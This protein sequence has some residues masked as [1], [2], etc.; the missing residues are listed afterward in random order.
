M[1]GPQLNAPH[2]TESSEGGGKDASVDGAEL[3]ELAR[4]EALELGP[5]PPGAE[6]EIWRENAEAGAAAR[7][8]R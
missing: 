6:A 7:R 3:R 8:P 5:E 4:Q 1:A 2:P